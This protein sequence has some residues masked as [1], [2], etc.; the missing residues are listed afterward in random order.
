[1]KLSDKDKADLCFA[2]A[3]FAATYLI[4][5]LAAHGIAQGWW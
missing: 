3:A 1:M 4:I 2:F 5:V